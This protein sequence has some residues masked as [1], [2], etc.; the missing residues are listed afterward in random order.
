MSPILE[1][2]GEQYAAWTLRPS[3]SS[4]YSR[5]RAEPAAWTPDLRSGGGAEA[6]FFR[7]KDLRSEARV[8]ER[9]RGLRARIP[10][11]R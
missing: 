5:L 4:R 7:L 11:R 3:I 2:D 6:L 10:R 1:A 9:E 8:A